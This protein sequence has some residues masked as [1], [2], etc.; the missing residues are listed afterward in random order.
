MALNDTGL[1][2][3]DLSRLHGYIGY[4]VTWVARLHV[5]PGGVGVCSCP[6]GGLADV[7]RGTGIDRDRGRS[8]A[9]ET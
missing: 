2:L 3:K 1:S 7:P 6:G 8:A 9:A 4:K 5:Y